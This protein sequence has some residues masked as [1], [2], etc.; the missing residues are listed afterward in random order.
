MN[1]IRVGDRMINMDLVTDVVREGDTVSLFFAVLAPQREQPYR[2]PA[3]EMATYTVHCQGDEA[4]ALWT[5]LEAHAHA[6]TLSSSNDE[7]AS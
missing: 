3:R 7:P 1:L 4:D 5:W 2:P 6:I